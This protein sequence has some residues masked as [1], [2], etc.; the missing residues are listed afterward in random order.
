MKIDILRGRIMSPKYIERRFNAME[1]EAAAYWKDWMVSGDKQDLALS[2]R[3]RRKA[4][5]YLKKIT[6][7]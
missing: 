2:G 5:Y 7:K 3:Y 4:Y 1:R 6:K